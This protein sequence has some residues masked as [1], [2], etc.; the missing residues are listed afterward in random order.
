[1]ISELR[2]SIPWNAFGLPLFG[3]ML[4]AVISSATALLLHSLLGYTRRDLEI[5]I[6]VFTLYG[7]LGGAFFG[8][9]NADTLWRARRV[10][11]NEK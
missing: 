6:V 4:C 1:M 11:P 10:S 9:R 8:W 7:L 5:S 3:A 2:K